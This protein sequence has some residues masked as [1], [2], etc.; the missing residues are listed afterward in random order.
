MR[1]LDGGREG[2]ADHV[3]WTRR[4]RANVG[5]LKVFAF[6]GIMSGQSEKDFDFGTSCSLRSGNREGVRLMWGGG[7]VPL[8]QATESTLTRTATCSRN[9]VDKVRTER[10]RSSTSTPVV[11]PCLVDPIACPR[12]L[13]TRW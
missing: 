4:A 1:R 7:P 13:S 6:Q 12:R 2:R 8:V 11:W 9:V 10:T 5:L 3:G